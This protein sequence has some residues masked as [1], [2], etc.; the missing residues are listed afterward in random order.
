MTAQNI[1]AQP[2]LL[3][4][5]LVRDIDLVLMSLLAANALIGTWLPSTTLLVQALINQFWLISTIHIS[6]SLYVGNF[7]TKRTVIWLLLVGATVSIQLVGFMGYVLPW[8]Q[9]SF[10]LA[11]VLTRFWEWAGGDPSFVWNLS[12]PWPR[13]GTIFG[14]TLAILFLFLLMILLAADVIAL[15]HAESRHKS[16]RRLVIFLCAAMITMVIIKLTILSFAPIA[17]ETAPQ[18]TY[19]DLPAPPH[20]VPSWL[21]LPSYAI[22]R[23]VP[24]KLAAIITMFAAMLMPI[25][26][27]W[28]RADALR[29]GRL[30]WPWRLC[31]LAMVAV[32]IGLGYLGS[33]LPVEPMLS[34]AQILTVLYFGFFLSP[35]LLH[36]FDSRRARTTPERC[37]QAS[38]D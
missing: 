19:P 30:K 6:L 37:S 23:C 4:R 38:A 25:I 16:I 14:T 1:T 7:S 22:L 2:S 5:P 27:P 34:I 12:F 29:T 13:M 31:C 3:P 28:A 24:N 21:E 36:W 9:M 11:T 18:S 17:P 33:Q 10:W 32:Y 35:F 26:W 15:H 8:G 20:I